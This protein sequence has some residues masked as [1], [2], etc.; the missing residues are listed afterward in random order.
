MRL[1][2]VEDEPQMADFIAK[3]LREESYAVDVAGDG[4]QAL[5][6]AEINTYD[7]LILDVRLP[8]KDGFSVCRE[9]RARSFRAPILMLT[10][11]DDVEDLVCGLNCGADDY[12]VKPFDFRVLLARIRA[13]LRRGEQIRPN[14]MQVDDV[15][16]NT[17][18]HTATRGPRTV[19]LTAKEY[20]LLELFM[21]HPREILGRE[22]IADHVWDDQ[23]DPF[24]N[25]IDVYV[26]RLRK[27]ID[28]GFE[29]HLIQ[30]RRHE[31]YIFAPAAGQ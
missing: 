14:V 26:N 5:Y 2:L 22:A 18:D 4:E 17:L 31:G 7:F 24:S 1:L 28:Q 27:K 11:M 13:L 16:L 23:F 29:R 12:M 21:L 10:A 3:G 25:L 19:T 6:C 15:T 8:R 30:T 20:A 9:L